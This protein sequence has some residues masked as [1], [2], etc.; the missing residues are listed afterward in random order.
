MAQT[1]KEVTKQI[2]SG[3]GREKCALWQVA[4]IGQDQKYLKKFF[5]FILWL[6]SAIKGPHYN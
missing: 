6:I 4:F 5:M 2:I 3:C 1:G